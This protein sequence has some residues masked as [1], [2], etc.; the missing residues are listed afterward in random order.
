M[1]LDLPDRGR[2]VKVE[3]RRV[4][5]QVLDVEI[6]AWRGDEPAA[7]PMA[8]R[9]APELEHGVAGPADRE[10][11]REPGEMA[12]DGPQLDVL[13][14]EDVTR[15]ADRL[16]LDLLDE[17]VAAVPPLARVAARVV[18]VAT[19]EVRAEGR[20]DRWRQDV[21]GRDQ[22]EG[23]SAPGGVALDEVLDRASRR[24]GSRS[25]HQLA[26]LGFRLTRR[27]STPTPQPA[28][29]PRMRGKLLRAFA[30]VMFT[31]ATLATTAA[32]PPPTSAA[33]PAASCQIALGDAGMI[34]FDHYP[35]PIGTVK[36]L[37]IFVDFP[38]APA[39]PSTTTDASRDNLVDGPAEWLETASYGKLHLDITAIPGWFRMPSPSTSYGWD[40]GLTTDTHAA[41]VA[42]AVAAADAAVNFA[43]YQLYYIVPNPEATAI[44][45]SPAFVFGPDQG[46]EADGA[47]IGFGS[48]FGQDAWDWGYGVLVHETGH[49]FGLPDLYSEEGVTHQFVGGWDVM[50]D[51]AAHSPDHLAWFK[52][53]L[54]WL[55]DSQMTC[56]NGAGTEDAVIT[57]LETVGG[58]KAV[59]MRTGSQR[60]T[61]AEF[62]TLN[63]VNENACSSG[64]LVYTINTAVASLEGPVVVRDGHPGEEL[65]DGCTYELD[66]AARVPGDRDWVETNGLRISVVSMS[67]TAARLRITRTASYPPDVKHTRK[68]SL[69]TSTSGSLVTITGRL[70]V[71]PGLTA[72]IASRSVRL[73]TDRTGT[74]TTI[75][76][77]NANASGVW[78]YR[79][80]PA[81]ARYRLVAPAVTIA[82]TPRHICSVATSRIVSLR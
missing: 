42:D 71:T 58:R 40:R 81:T 72:C 20:E 50:G 66:D 49:T 32:D 80:N 23:R 1:A 37:M 15:E 19:L 6:D 21:L 70:T 61:V 35:R 55:T 59:V 62:R 53:Q 78:T 76:T 18:G 31:A 14:S 45:F 64:I 17:P 28:T 7:F 16:V 5:G 75:R 39:A 82:G 51:I 25:V 46:I 30:L 27:T 60:V 24:G 69:T 36:A 34:N 4:E 2:R 48:T 41:Y 44:S 26:S 9:F 79:F 52:W 67:D 68:L 33:V 43:G 65:P 22:V 63:G 57:P 8:A 38:D 29:L 13:G 11:D 54:G 12:G 10:D 56:I 47:P 73:Q 74:W 77:A 3:A